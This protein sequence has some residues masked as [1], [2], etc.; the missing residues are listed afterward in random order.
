[1]NKTH[2]CWLFFSLVL[3]PGCKMTTEKFSKT[4]YPKIIESAAKVVTTKFYEGVYRDGEWICG[5]EV[6]PGYDP[7]DYLLTGQ[8]PTIEYYNKAGNIVLFVETIQ[9]KPVYFQVTEYVTPESSQKKS[10]RHIRWNDWDITEIF[11]RDKNGRLVKVKND[12]EET[13]IEYDASGQRSKIITTDNGSKKIVKKLPGVIKS[14]SIEE[15]DLYWE[16]NYRDRLK[17]ETIEIFDSND[18]LIEQTS[19]IYNE[20]GSQWGTSRRIVNYRGKKITEEFYEKR[21]LDESLEKRYVEKWH[22][23]YNSHGDVE[24]EDFETTSFVNRLNTLTNT[25]FYYYEYNSKGEWI[26]RTMVWEYHSF[27]PGKIET[28][29]TITVRD[30]SYK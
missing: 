28:R 29:A 11:Y 24:I 15:Y 21:A 20:D 23:T 14:Y 9:D 4:Q 16:D 26:K 10:V 17:E 22:T 19:K 18:N 8:K 2:I 3:F 13:I 5:K 12:V 1:M 30:I 7:D 6:E 27:Y 25:R